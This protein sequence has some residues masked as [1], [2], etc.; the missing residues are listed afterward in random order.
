MYSPLSIDK[1]NSQNESYPWQVLSRDVLVIPVPKID[2]VS[3]CTWNKNTLNIVNSSELS[4]SAAH[5]S[6][7]NRQY[8]WLLAYIY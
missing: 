3:A 2:L 4:F 7:A 1:I 8:L 5:S 6:L